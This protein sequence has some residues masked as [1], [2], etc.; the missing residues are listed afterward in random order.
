M[1]PIKR[2]LQDRIAERIEPNKVVLIFGA[3]R[4]GKT[5]LMRQ[6]INGFSGKTLL[7]NGEDYDTLALME[8][9]SIANYR[10]LLEGVDLLAID[11]AQNIPEIGSKLKLIVDE[12]EGV[13]VIA[14]GSSSFDLL[15]KAGEPLVGRSTQFHLTPFSQKEIAPSETALETRQNLESRLIYGSYPEVVIMDSFGGKTDYLRDIVGAYLLKDILS[16]D[17]LKNSGKL[18][19]LLR[20]IAFQ[21][22]NEVSYDELG[23]QIGMSKNTVEKYLDLLSK[24][25]V[26]YRLGA[27]ARNLR[28]EVSKAGKW[29]F[30]DNGIRNAIIGNFNPL[31]IRQDVGP[32]WENYIISERIKA[33]YNNGLGKEFYFW[34]T[35][36]RQEIDLIEE[37]SN[38][39]MALEIKWGNKNPEAPGIFKEAYPNATFDVINKDNYLIKF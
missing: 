8:E 21:L 16:I 11:E 39:L 24:V 12:I 13:R 6:L 10:H 7:L 37:D 20:L 35:Y 5:I 31:S 19:E 28:K 38:S 30:Y 32:L 26:V 17:G 29:Y 3:R 15:N 9:R 22:G 33:N 36:D 23:K 4:V 18:K 14:S 1:E 25:F 2:L 34:R 27:Y